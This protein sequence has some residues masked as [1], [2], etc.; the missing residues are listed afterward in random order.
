M[1]HR[2]RISNEFALTVGYVGQ[3]V[4]VAVRGDVDLLTAPDLA[5]ILT[6][7]TDRGHANVVLDFSELDFLDA[8]GLQ[9]IADTS[10]R[11][12]PSGSLSVR[13]LP[14]MTHRILDITGVSAMV[15]IEPSVAVG[16]NGRGAATLFRH[17]THLAFSQEEPEDRR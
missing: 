9:V 6:A 17:A 8:A 16:V 14:P 5:A 11:L 2:C 7:V 13:A 3:Q 12:Q 1:T 4:V 15:H 10:A